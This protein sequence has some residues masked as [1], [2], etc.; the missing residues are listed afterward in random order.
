MRITLPGSDVRTWDGYLGERYDIVLASPPCR[1]FTRSNYSMPLSVTEQID[2]MS[3]VD[4]IIRI[5]FMTKPGKWCIENPPGRLKKVLGN[6]RYT[7][8]PWWYGG[9]TQKT[10]CL[11][12]E[13]EIPIR[14]FFVR[15][16][17]TVSTGCIGR[18]GDYRRAI[19]PVGFAK[20]FYEANND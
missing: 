10:T 2:A 18:Q 12:G 1:C 13:F 14:E 3:V 20:A 7:F 19:T 16:G 15:P 11:W 17:K 4:A 9:N 5:I 8:Q 6:P